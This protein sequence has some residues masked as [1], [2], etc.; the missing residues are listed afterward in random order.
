MNEMKIEIGDVDHFTADETAEVKACFAG[1]G[2]WHGGNA[3]P[4]AAKQ[5]AGGFE[6]PAWAPD[7]QPANLAAAATD[8]AVWL[9]MLEE[10]MDMRRFPDHRFVMTITNHDRLN[11]CRAALKG[12]LV[13]PAPPVS[14]EKDPA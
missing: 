13:P 6:Y 2:G 10:Y 14:G 3:S 1:V 7:G 4:G 12:F 5:D 8:A 11:A 9:D